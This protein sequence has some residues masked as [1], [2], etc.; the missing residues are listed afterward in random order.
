MECRLR[1]MSYLGTIQVDI[2]IQYDNETNG[3]YYDVQDIEIGKI[4]I[5]IGS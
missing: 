5:M 2:E 4:P 3:F 1:E